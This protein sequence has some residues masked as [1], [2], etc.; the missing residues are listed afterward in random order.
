MLVRKFSSAYSKDLL[1]LCLSRSRIVK[2]TIKCI[3]FEAASV[4][5]LRDS[6][7]SLNLL[8]LLLFSESRI[9]LTGRNVIW[10]RIS[11]TFR[12][13]QVHQARMSMLV[14]PTSCHASSWHKRDWGQHYEWWMV[15]D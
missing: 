7:K 9:I 13:A 4:F 3:V 11:L 15:G 1:T 8:L 12:R 2:T 5:N 10:F 14:G 6:L